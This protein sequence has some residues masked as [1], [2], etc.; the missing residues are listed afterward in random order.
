M[1]IIFHTLLKLNLILVIYFHGN[2][3]IS[4]RSFK[5]PMVVTSSNH[6]EIFMIHEASYEIVWLR[7]IIQYVQYIQ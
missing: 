1:L 7:F 4:W 6:L 3:I 5:Q 2:I